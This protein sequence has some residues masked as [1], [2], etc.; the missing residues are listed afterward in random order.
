MFLEEHEKNELFSFSP[1]AVFDDFSG[2]YI[3]ISSY[4]NEKRMNIVRWMLVDVG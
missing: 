3:C 1:K 4:Y 2:V